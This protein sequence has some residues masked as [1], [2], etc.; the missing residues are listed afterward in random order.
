M[1]NEGEQGT[2]RHP[3]GRRDSPENVRQAA[4]RDRGVSSDLM[5]R[6]P[7]A[8]DG[9]MHRPARIYERDHPGKSR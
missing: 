9:G 2:G 7:R 3:P 5:S 8:P 4:G 1:P 6:E